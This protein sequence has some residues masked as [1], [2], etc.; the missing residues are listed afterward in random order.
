MS[1]PV[2]DENLD[3]EK[4][5]I[6]NGEP[7]FRYGS[8]TIYN[9]I[10]VG[11]INRP[12][13]S[14]AVSS[15]EMLYAKSITVSSNKDVI[16]QISINSRPGMTGSGNLTSTINA[17]RILLNAGDSK[18]IPIEQV[19]KGSIVS[20]I[21]INIVYNRTEGTEGFQFSSGLN[22]YMAYE[23]I[24]FS[25]PK[26]T[27]FFGDSVMIGNTGSTYKYQHFVW[28]I[29]KHF[30]SIKNN[31]QILN[32]G[33]SG[34]TSQIVRYMLSNNYRSVSKNV[35]YIFENH[36]IN[37][38]SQSTSDPNFESYL[39]ELIAFKKTNNP[40]ST[41]I[42]LGNTPVENNTLNTRCEELR[43]MKQNKVSELNDPK[44]LYCN[45]GNAFDRTNASFY[46]N[47]DTAGNRLH[48]NDA[49]NAAIYTV[50][51]QFFID[52]NLK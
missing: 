2:N 29:K 44:I 5:F 36:G 51:N 28:Q 7:I 17:Y 30:E 27:I 37:D 40:N 15:K 26:K 16:M 39:D 24:D 47:S 12:Y 48:P 13:S 21:G 45:L 8:N 20:S 43:L 14:I 33:I 32:Y 42:L 38:A 6:Q 34:S 9:D 49:G 18:V 19:F 1:F 22:G 46:V 52:N 10:A 3:L 25:I 23:D 4:W 50:L 35:Q 31:F 41:L 11:E